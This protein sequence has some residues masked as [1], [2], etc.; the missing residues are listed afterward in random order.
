MQNEFQVTTFAQ[1]YPRESRQHQV[2]SK[3]I[4]GEVEAPKLHAWW[5]HQFL[6]LGDLATRRSKIYGLLV[7]QGPTCKFSEP[8]K[9]SSSSNN[10]IE[11]S[12]LDGDILSMS[13]AESCK[14]SDCCRRLKAVSKLMLERAIESRGATVYTSDSTMR[15]SV[16]D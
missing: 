16:V 2:L 8:Q 11:R 7:F 1:L 5:K 15:P 3:L 10:K 13:I 6:F 4:C 14:I 12:H 9:L